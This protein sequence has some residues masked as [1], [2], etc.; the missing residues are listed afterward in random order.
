MHLSYMTLCEYIELCKVNLFRY[1]MLLNE[2]Q[3]EMV[4]NHVTSGCIHQC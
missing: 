4:G 3:A 2:P 1:A